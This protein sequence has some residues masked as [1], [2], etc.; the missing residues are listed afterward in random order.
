MGGLHLAASVRALANRS[1]ASP[2]RVGRVILLGSQ[3]KMPPTGAAPKGHPHEGRVGYRVAQTWLSMSQL[4]ERLPAPL[5]VVTLSG[6]PFCL[7]RPMA[8]AA[9]ISA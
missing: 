2:P 8:L 7:A 6:A 4:R 9:L 5:P 3:K 1:G